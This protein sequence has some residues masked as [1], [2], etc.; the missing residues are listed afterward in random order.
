MA[1]VAFANVMAVD[2]VTKEMKGF[3]VTD[4]NGNFQL[5]LEKNTV[6]ELKITFVGFKPISEYI[7][8]DQKPEVPLM[9]LM[10]EA[11]NALDQVT[12]VAE[13]PV[14][15][16]GDTISYKADAFTK[17]DE[18]KLEDVLEELPGFNIRDN[19]DIEVQ[20]KRVEKVLVDG[21][22][23]FEGDTKLATKNIPADVIDRVQ[24]LQNYNDVAPMQGLMDNDRLAINI[25]LKPDKKRIVFGDIEAGGGPEERYFGH[26]NAFYYAPKTSINFIGDGNNVGELALS[27]TDYFR[28]SGGLASLASRSGTSYRVNA[29]DMDI[30]VTSRNSA[31]DLTN[32]LG[33]MNFTSNPSEKVRISGFLIGFDTESILGSNSLRTYPQLDASTQEQLQTTTTLGNQSG[34]GRFSMTFKPSYKMQVDYNFF[35]KRGAIDQFTMR[36]SEL[37][38]GTNELTEEQERK[39]TSQTHQLRMFNAL[40][41]KNILSAELS[42]KE[43]NV[44]TDQYLTSQD[45]LFEGL[46]DVDADLQFL[47]QNQRTNTRQ[48]DA[49]F[50]YYYILNGK[51]HLNAAFGINHSN[52]LLTANLSGDDVISAPDQRLNITNRYLRL[53]YKKKWDKLTV[54]PAVNLNNYAISLAE[55]PSDRPSYL[56]PQLNITY[57][58]GTSHSLD[59]NYRESIEYNDVAGYT[60]GFLL[61]RYN[62]LSFGN[63]LLLPAR[64]NTVAVSYR[65]FN[66]YNFFNIFGGLN[67]Q[68]IKDGFTNNQV[69]D[70]I[71]NV[72]N[73][74]N[75]TQANQ[76]SSAYL[77]VEKRF[78]YVRLNGRADLQQTILNNELEGEVIEND[79]FTQMYTFNASARLFKKLSVRAGYNVSINRYNSGVISS[80][81]I[82]QRPTF[83][84]TYT[85]KGLRFDAEYAFNKYRNPAQDQTTL[86]DI[87]DISLSYRKAKSPWE[88]KVQGLNLLNTTSV[89]RDSFSD[90]L[91]STF[92]YDIQRRY[93]L[94]T[95]KYD[96]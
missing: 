55:G 12:V 76:V 46:L 77:T 30:P 79:N 73:T 56:F 54:S 33:A 1:P 78:N 3:T 38:S 10:R 34:L 6:Y 8:Y 40:N 18:R 43:E 50:N 25:E 22:E 59:V 48:Y 87:L 94:F 74:I 85:L 4:V 13:M 81:F 21:K 7:R 16:Q 26:A 57:D 35:G 2:T 24:V 17:G 88:F 92:S 65:N 27:V 37:L 39:P 9:I 64:Y 49:A 91:I 68:Y 96:L 29:G 42:F 31:S 84:T 80:K 63:S 75:A 41:E 11:V 14:V 45:P 82:N 23:F 69:L 51:T 44:D 89:Q 83:S 90:N 72:S 95:I 86:F 67:F 32:Y 19:G 28:M 5:R 61:Q 60:E 52:Q 47:N 58:F 70:G 20:G 93:G 71:D 66:S 15:M 53:Q 62:T 36:D